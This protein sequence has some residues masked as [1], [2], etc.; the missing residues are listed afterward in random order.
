MSLLCSLFPPP[1][2]TGAYVYTSLSLSSPSDPTV[3]STAIRDD[4]CAVSFRSSSEGVELSVVVDGLGS[5]WSSLTVNDQGVGSSW[6][7]EVALID[8][9]SVAVLANRRLSFVASLAE[10]GS[11][12]V[13]LDDITLHPCI[14]CNTPGRCGQWEIERRYAVLFLHPL[15]RGGTHFVS[16]WILFLSS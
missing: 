13:A 9:E 3:A 2:P 12:Y 15:S 4:Y 6:L 7:D 5:V 10:G 16:S 1:L 11:G 14:D 8:L